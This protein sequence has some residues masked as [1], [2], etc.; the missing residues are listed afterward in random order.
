MFIEAIA[1]VRGVADAKA[2]LVAKIR[3][4]QFL[5]I[6]LAGKVVAGPC[7]M[8]LPLFL[9]YGAPGHLMLAAPKPLT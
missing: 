4:K 5:A 2:T 1:A 6:P 9:L 3:I 8:T 7:M